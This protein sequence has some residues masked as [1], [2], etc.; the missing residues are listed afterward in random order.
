ML[1]PHISLEELVVSQTAVRLGIDNTPPAP[2]LA[3]LL[4][5]AEGL[6]RIRVVL[7]NR[8]ITITSGYR[9]ARLNT[10]LGG[11]SDSRHLVGLAADILCPSFGSP[12]AV[13]QAIVDAGLE[14]DQV[15]HEGKW[16]HAA[17]PAAGVAARGQV[18]TAHFSAGRATYTNGLS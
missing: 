9:C 5:L 7:G 2:L 14:I 17:F 18:L 8:P 4:L 1:T 6:E 13:C 12:L 11:A 3:H 15:I 16:C 10:V